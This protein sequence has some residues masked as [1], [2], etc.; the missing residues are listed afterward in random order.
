[1]KNEQRQYFFSRKDH[2]GI[3][4][5]ILLEHL[6]EAN[7]NMK[8]EKPNKPIHVKPSFY[9]YCFEPL[10]QIALKY[11][12][13]LVLHG[14][15]NRDMDLIAIPWGETIGDKKVMV[16]EMCEYLGGS[17]MEETPEA[18]EQFMKS[19]HGRDNYVINVYRTIDRYNMTG[20]GKI[21]PV[22]YL[23][24]SITPSI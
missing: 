20:D 3:P 9:A 5:N 17:I 4:E 23:D 19:H 16:D 12:Y 24:I 18:H 14:S 2:G 11:G 8:D 7:A 22:Y 15:L 21:D 10:K 1:M 13:N 6:R